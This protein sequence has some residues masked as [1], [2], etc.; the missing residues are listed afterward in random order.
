MSTRGE[1][2]RG[3]V[4]FN[5]DSNERQDFIAHHLT[6]SHLSPFVIAA[7]R[8]KTFLLLFCMFTFAPEV[9]V[10]CKFAVAAR[11]R[12]RERL[13]LVRSPCSRV[14]AGAG[15]RRRGCSPL[16]AAVS[17]LRAVSGRRCCCW[18]SYPVSS[19]SAAVRR[20]TAMFSVR[21]KISAS[22]VHPCAWNTCQSSLIPDCRS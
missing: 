10:C 21:N 4:F 15:N 14:A 3:N 1:G 20:W 6:H 8:S 16:H 17:L 2:N 12:R 9:T 5:D 19:S 13:A 7:F 22:T 18:A 11:R